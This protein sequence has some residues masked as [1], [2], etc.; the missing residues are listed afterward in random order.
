MIEMTRKNSASACPRRPVIAS[1]AAL[2]AILAGFFAGNA[3]ARTPDP[4][5][6]HAAR[7][8]TYVGRFEGAKGYVGVIVGETGA[9]RAYALEPTRRLAAW[10]APVLPD[11]TIRDERPGTP[12][13]RYI[14]SSN[15]F[16]LEAT[17]SSG[18]IIGSVS[19][20]SGERYAFDARRVAG[21]HTLHEILIGR[22]PTRYLGGWV[23]W[24]KASTIGYLDLPPVVQALMLSNG[25][26]S[27]S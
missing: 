6:V 24:D 25:D 27:G 11:L 18:Q 14:T 9:I 20:P 2:A 4:V 5:G 21:A 12:Y 19:F 10:T 16:S 17:A 1:L 26:G 8:G 13:R 3:S 15:G 7:A 23:V 22:G